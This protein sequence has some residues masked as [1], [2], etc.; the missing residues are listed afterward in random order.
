[1]E[2]DRNFQMASA[3]RSLTIGSLRPDQQYPVVH[4]ER[5]NT[6]YGPSVLLAILE[7]STFS[8]K[9]FL[10]KR[11]CEVVSDEDTEVINS[12]RVLLYLVYKGTCPKSNSC[13]LELQRQKQVS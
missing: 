8:M 1:M 4:A 12:G 10:P 11:Y 3:C 6:R 5:V 7:N 9:F 2:L 13:V